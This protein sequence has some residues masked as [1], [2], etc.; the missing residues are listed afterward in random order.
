VSPAAS[1]CVQGKPKRLASSTVFDPD[2]PNR[3]AYLSTDVHDFA[4]PADSRKWHVPVQQVRCEVTAVQ[5]PPAGICMGLRGWLYC[6]CIPVVAT[7]CHVPVV[8]NWSLR[9]SMCVSL[10]TPTPTLRCY[11]APPTQFQSGL[12]PDPVASWWRTRTPLW[13]QGWMACPRRST[14]QL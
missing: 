8:T 14:P 12:L 3:M 4:W 9:V 2:A 13:L 7:S 5:P 11:P 10:Q 6:C 1:T